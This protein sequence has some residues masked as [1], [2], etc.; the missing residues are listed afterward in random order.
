MLFFTSGPHLKVSVVQV[1]AQKVRK[2]PVTVLVEICLFFNTSMQLPPAVKV[3]IFG[4]NM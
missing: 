1:S 4:I 2:T 3:K